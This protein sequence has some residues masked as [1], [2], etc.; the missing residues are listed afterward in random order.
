MQFS[1]CSFEKKSLG[2]S[3]PRVPVDT[4]CFA[5][6]IEVKNRKEHTEN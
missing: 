6:G 3:C 5:T 2:L 4:Y 1:F